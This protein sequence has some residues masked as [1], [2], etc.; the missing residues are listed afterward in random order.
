MER[1]IRFELDIAAPS[2]EVWSVL[3]EADQIPTWWEGV[4]AVKLTDP[5]PGGV[6]TLD[7]KAGR[8]DTCEILESDPGK[9][10]RFRW[11]S[12]EPEPTT[13]EYRLEA[14]EGGT[15]LHF[16]N[17]GYKPGPKWDKVYD[18]NFSGWVSM[19]LGVRRLLE[20]AHRH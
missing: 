11:M 1:A 12:S 19:L 20:T 15:R 5:K 17:T 14:R 18:A 3:T 7:Y 16:S 9:L 10:L 2:R 6:Y 4:H 13:V 8:P